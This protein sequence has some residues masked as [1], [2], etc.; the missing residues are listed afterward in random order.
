MRVS[1]N[2]GTPELVISTEAPEQV[3]GPQMLPGGEWVLFT[4]TRLTSV[5]GITRW[6]E[7]Q[8]VVQSLESGERKILWE[9]GSDARYVV[10]LPGISSMR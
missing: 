10:G 4:L 6:D 5:S 2:G 9:G 8:I 1:A 7:A 3:H